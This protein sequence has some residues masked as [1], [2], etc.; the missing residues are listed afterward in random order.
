[1]P[2]PNSDNLSEPFETAS[3]ALAKDL[4]QLHRE[5]ANIL[6]SQKNVVEPRQ[7]YLDEVVRRLVDPIAEHCHQKESAHEIAFY[8]KSFLKALPLFMKGRLPVAGLIAS[9]VADEA[10]IGDRA[11]DQLVDAG[12]GVLKAGSLKL[13]FSTLGRRGLTPGLQGV[14]MGFGARTSEA[15]FTREN[16]LD[17]QRKFSF[18]KGLETTA[19]IALNPGALIVD[20][21]TAGVADVYWARLFNWS[22]G[23]AFYSPHLTHS[24]TAG[25]MG[26]TS[27]F[28]NELHRQLSDN[29]S[30]DLSLLAKRS[31]IQ[32]GV[33]SLAGGIGGWQTLRKSHLNFSKDNIDASA[34]AR[35]T[36][37]QRGEV[38]D[39]HQFALKEGQFILE[40]KLPD[41]TTET[42]VGWTKLKDGT[43]VRSIFRP[44]DGTLKFAQRM[45]SEIAA[46]GMQSLG[47]KANMPVT[48][49][50]T[51]EVN[52][53]PY[54]GYLQEMEGISLADFMRES[55][56]KKQPSRG[57]IRKY[58]QS[59]PV[60][61]ESFKDAYLHRL[62][63]GEWDNHAL[64]MTV[65][66]TQAGPKVRNIDFGD[67][68][69]PAA[70]SFDIT[71]T[72]GVRQ[73]YDRINAYLYKELSGRKLGF[74]REAY[75]QGLADQYARPN[76]IQKLQEIGLTNQQI[77]GVVG[78]VNWLAKEGRFPVG[79]EAAFY[80]NLNDARRK[81]EQWLGK[82]SVRKESDQTN[83]FKS[84]P[85]I[86]ETGK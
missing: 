71:P 60:F 20:A 49:A 25:A 37:F 13:T 2:Y 41:L 80:L 32:G 4:S 38:A 46:Y 50:K 18:D 5:S 47:L 61:V 75:I 19:S 43:Y 24:L 14:G 1:M 52:G 64:N 11:Q 6:Y 58:V 7:S 68:L 72:P 85:R 51:I 16:Y 86:H 40:K 81:V 67:S 31:L 82:R 48:V 26:I 65:K 39:S 23:R 29:Q 22:R 73:G 78:R 45:Q 76:G 9:Y 34:K 66:T 59:N 21:A 62:I 35:L 27:G 79:S 53:K 30:I 69:H 36:S 57:E 44:N 54:D 42:W 84:E 12:L 74:D 55:T 33:D 15:L 10:K 63:M 77:D 70:T 8:C 28:G 17:S 56:G 3:Q 83:Y